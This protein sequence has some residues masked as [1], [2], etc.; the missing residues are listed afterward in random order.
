MPI[1]SSAIPCASHLFGT[2]GTFILNGPL[3]LITTSR[4]SCAV[5][6]PL[7]SAGLKR[8]VLPIELMVNSSSSLIGAIEIKSVAGA[9]FWDGGVRDTAEIAPTVFIAEMKQPLSCKLARMLKVSSGVMTEVPDTSPT[10]QLNRTLLDDLPSLQEST[11]GISTRRSIAKPGDTVAA[12]LEL[13][14]KSL[15][16]KFDVRV[17]AVIVS[18]SVPSLTNF[19]AIRFIEISERG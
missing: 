7:E 14:T 11:G 2:I 5:P 4:S 12:R 6:I 3:V 16:N 19:I 9:N 13:Q 8:V 17:A 18:G 10:L 1:L 15:A